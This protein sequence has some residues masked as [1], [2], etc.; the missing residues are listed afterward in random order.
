[1][2]RDR[3]RHE[4]QHQRDVTGRV[5]R[6]LANGKTQAAF[7]TWANFAIVAR[8][9]EERY[10]H[11]SGL[12]QMRKEIADAQQPVIAILMTCLILQMLHSTAAM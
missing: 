9:E 2:R 1:M 8:L 5:L 3:Y 6:R 12:E 10:G 11:L 7:R 4:R